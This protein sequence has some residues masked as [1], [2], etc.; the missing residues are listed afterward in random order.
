MRFDRSVVIALALVF[1]LGGCVRYYKTSDIRSSLHRA[2]VDTGRMVKEADKVLVRARSAL[3]TLK[4]ETPDIPA[5]TLGMLDAMVAD[6]EKGMG[7]IRAGSR[8]INAL[9]KRFEGIAGKKKKIR[10]DRPEW[11]EVERLK[12]DL[13]S[14]HDKLEMALK[15]YKKR[16]KRLEKAVNEAIKRRTS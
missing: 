16:L 14:L 8:K 10:S 3:R 6:L 5:G 15:E 13:E 7:P 9:V 4:N 11:D 12:A 2:Q 1:G